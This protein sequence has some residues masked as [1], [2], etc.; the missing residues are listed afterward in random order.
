LM[1]H[2]GIETRSSAVYDWSSNQWVALWHR[3]RNRKEGVDYEGAVFDL[4]EYLT[5]N[6]ALNIL[7][8]GGQEGLI[9][10][11]IGIDACRLRKGLNTRVKAML[12][13]R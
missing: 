10:G 5:L 1:K 9:D 13:G 8:H 2:S 7:Q 3:F 12:K 6:K 11:I 4:L